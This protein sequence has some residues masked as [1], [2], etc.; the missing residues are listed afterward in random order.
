[1]PRSPWWW[2]MS[3]LL[4]SRGW[5]HSASKEMAI[6]PYITCINTCNYLHS[7][8]ILCV[9]ICIYIIIYIIYNI[10]YIIYFI[11]YIIFYIILNIIFYIIYILYNIHTSLIFVWRNTCIC[12][13][14]Y[15][16]VYV[17]VFTYMYIIVIISICKH[18]NTIDAKHLFI[19]KNWPITIHIYLFSIH[20][21]SNIYMYMYTYVNQTLIIKYIVYTHNIYKKYTPMHRIEVI[22]SSLYYIHVTWFRYKYQSYIKI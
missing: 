7:Y 2:A 18:L 1:M 10:L 19:S 8:I 6:W 20:W 12:I 21:Y 14:I 4:W 5:P 15:M 17:C 9:Y 13:Y 22:E 11:L 16:H 3:T